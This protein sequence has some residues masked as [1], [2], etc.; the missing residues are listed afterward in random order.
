MV[1]TRHRYLYAGFVEDLIANPFKTAFA[2]QKPYFFL[3]F[4]GNM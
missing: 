1:T 4:G 3:F 2:V